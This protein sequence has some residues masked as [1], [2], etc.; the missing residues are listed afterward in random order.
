MDCRASLAMTRSDA[1]AKPREGCDSVARE[2]ADQ[3]RDEGK[4]WSVF[5]WRA[6]SCLYAVCGNAKT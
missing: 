3:V 6:V 1:G 2:I 5:R 4:G